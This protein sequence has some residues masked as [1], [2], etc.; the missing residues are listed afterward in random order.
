MRKYSFGAASV[1]LE[2]VWSLRAKLY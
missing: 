2:L 1:L